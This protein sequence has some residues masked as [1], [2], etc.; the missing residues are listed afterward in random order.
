MPARSPR[1]RSKNSVTVM[2]TVFVLVILGLILVCYLIPIFFSVKYVSVDNKDGSSTKAAAAG[3]V[4]PIATLPPKPV[5]THVRTPDSVRAIYM[6]SWVAGSPDIRKNLVKIMDD[7]EIN[8]VVIDIKDYSGAIVFKT[9]NPTIEEVGS[10]E[11]R[12]KDMKEFINMLHEK[13]I[14]VIGRIS[15]FQDAYLVKKKPELAVKRKSDGG[16]WKDYKGISWIDAGAKPAWDYLVQIGKASYDTGFDEL[17]FDY[18]RFP[19]DGNMKD[20]AYPFSRDQKKSDVLRTFFAYLHGQFRSATTTDAAGIIV[21]YN[22]GDGPVLSADLFGMTT[23][24]HDDLNIGQLIENAFPYFDYI[25]PMVYPSHYPATFLGYKNPSEKPY[26]VVKYAM[27]KAVERAHMASTSPD[28]LRPWLQDFSIGTTHYTP[29]MVRAQITATYDTGLDS[30]MLWSASNR[31]TLSALH[32][33][34]ASLTA[35]H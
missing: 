3:S 12:V 25:A 4:T 21:P 27:S 13:N 20:I 10:T 15:T 16:V 5:V 17:N 22:G 26:E 18:I 23:S 24:N 9:D 31:Y 33:E 7:T 19:S 8:A 35:A 30:W 32:S 14:Y 2:I 34:A 1:L 11:V 28:K 6:S 29:E